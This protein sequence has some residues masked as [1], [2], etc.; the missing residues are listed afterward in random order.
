MTIKQKGE[1]FGELVAI[2]QRLLAPDGCPWDRE[3]TLETLKPFLLEESYEVLEAME[4]GDAPNHCEELGDLLFQIVFQAE[5]R[6]VEGRFGIDDVVAAIASKLVRRHPHVFANT[7]VSGSSEVVANWG[8]LKAAEHAAK[9]KRRGTLEGVP[10]ALPAL[11]QAQRIGEK[12]AEVGFDWPDVAGVRD[13]VD[14]ELRE[15]DEALARKDAA[16]IGE[17]LGDLLFTLTRLAA[18][19]GV[20]PE[21]S[22]RACIHRFRARFEEM[23]RRAANQGRPLKEMSLEEMDALWR[24]AKAALVTGQATPASAPSK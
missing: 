20:G 18:K 4:L 3:Q 15:L 7:K 23:E 17:E 12:A 14:E 21:E 13:K 10:T 16:A 2:M 22:L 11:L 19:V 1:S 9:G 5:L 6:A 8:K 24:Q